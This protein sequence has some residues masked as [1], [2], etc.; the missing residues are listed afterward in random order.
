MKKTKNNNMIEAIKRFFGL[1]KF[2]VGDLCILLAD[3]NSGMTIKKGS[4][5]MI[6]SVSKGIEPKYLVKYRNGDYKFAWANTYDLK[7]K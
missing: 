1:T 5:V 4:V 6:H 3:A 7:K 2:K